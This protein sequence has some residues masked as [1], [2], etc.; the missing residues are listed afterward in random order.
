[1]ARAILLERF[2][3]W[4]TVVVSI[5]NESLHLRQDIKDDACSWWSLI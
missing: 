4:H 5:H 3:D 1:M 2:P